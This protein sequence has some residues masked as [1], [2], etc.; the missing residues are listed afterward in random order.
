MGVKEIIVID[1]FSEKFVEVKVMGCEK[2][3][4]VCYENVFEK[5]NEYIKGRGVD[6]VFECVGFFFI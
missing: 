4:Y 5:I 2:V 3:I 6:F 1:I